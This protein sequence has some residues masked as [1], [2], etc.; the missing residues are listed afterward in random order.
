VPSPATLD[1]ARARIRHRRHVG[2]FAEFGRFIVKVRW[3]VV[4][5]WIIVPIALAAALPSLASQVNNDTTAFLP[6]ASPSV[7]AA[8]LAAPII[9]NPS[10]AVVSV[11]ATS[12]TPLTSKLAART[13]GTLRA[14]L[15]AVP[16]VRRVDP[17]VLSGDGRAV[18]MV[19]V[20]SVSMFDQPATSTFV[21]DTIVAIDHAPLSSTI[22]PSVAGQVATN[23]ASQSTSQKSAST[24]TLFSLLFIIALLILIFRSPLAPVVTL[25]PAIFALRLADPIIGALGESGLKISFVAQLLLIVIILGAGTDYGLFLVFRVREELEHGRDRFDAVAA[26]LA[27]VGESITASAGTVIAA[28]L[29]LLLATF[30]MY[31]DL[32]IPLAIGVG[33]ILLAGL[34]LLPALL[35]IL[36]PVVFWPVRPSARPHR[37][38]WWGRIASRLVRRPVRTLTAGVLVLVALSI[39]ALFLKSAGFDQGVTAPAGSSAAVG[40]AAVAAHFPEQSSNPTALVFRFATPV[41]SS[42]T[43]LDV[44]TTHL[45]ESGQFTTL[46]GPLNPMGVAIGAHAFTTLYDAVGSPSAVVAR[47]QVFPPAGFTATEFAAYR[48]AV[49]YVSATGTTVQFE[50]GLSAGTPSSTAALNAVPQI[51][52]EVALAGLQ[53]G[54]VATGVAGQAPAFYDISST[55]SSDLREVVPIA[56]LAIGLVLALVLRSLTAPAYLVVSVV[57]SYT[58]SLGLA[59]IIFQGFRGYTGITFLLPFLLFIFLLAL[60]EDYNILVMTR[61]REENTHV[62]LHEAIVTAVGATGP[63]ITSAGLVLAG[64]FGVLAVAGGANG[65]GPQI[66]AIGV[67]L[68]AGIL[69]DTFVVRTLLVPSIVALLGR[70]NWWPSRLYREPDRFHE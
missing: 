66:V 53:V 43:E 20:S 44:L 39:G 59:V 4:A 56:V 57:L 5:L 9:G 45:A 32:A 31:H 14:V 11:V 46:S 22:Q 15:L 36:G 7:R 29:T 58:A 23:V 47:H 25:L 65:G 68:A 17:G 2:G 1:P 27:R 60:G 41:W 48:S 35:A 51:R 13:L 61:I 40:N 38:A 42:A 49:R 64:T 34:T 37:D 50:A 12:P 69:L 10:A 67:G 26:A 63:T 19:V 21:N 18:S 30:T 62:P 52:R 8:A 24:T 70:W 55:S 16:H 3:F 6:S 33:A 28:L 54:A